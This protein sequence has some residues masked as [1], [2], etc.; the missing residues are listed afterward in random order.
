MRYFL[1]M[2]ISLLVLLV[3]GGMVWWKRQKRGRGP[4]LEDIWLRLREE[5]V[6]AGPFVGPAGSGEKNI[7]ALPMA[8]GVP[9]CWTNLR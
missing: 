5:D 7:E 9:Q 3:L 1:P 4:A 2:G 6:Q 8:S